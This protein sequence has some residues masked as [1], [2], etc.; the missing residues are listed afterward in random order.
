MNAVIHQ[1]HLGSVQEH[2]PTLQPTSNPMRGLS[3][4]ELGR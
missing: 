2:S 3:A 1:L 4:A